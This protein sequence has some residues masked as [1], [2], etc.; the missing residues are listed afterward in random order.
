MTTKFWYDD[1]SILY[2]NK[3]VSNLENELGRKTNLTHSAV[4]QTG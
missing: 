3:F 4:I 2:D 1:I